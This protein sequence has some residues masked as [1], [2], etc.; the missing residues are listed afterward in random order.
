[1]KTGRE[2]FEK[3]Q[4]VINM[5]RG[6]RFGTEENLR[7][8][9]SKFG[10]TLPGMRVLWILQFEHQ[11]TITQI[12]KIGLWD[13]STTQRIITNLKK[14]N[15]VEVKKNNKDNR[16][17]IITLTDNSKQI[18]IN[19][20]KYVEEAIANPNVICSIE[21]S[22]YKFGEQDFNKFLDVGM[23]LCQEMIS[24]EYVDW[25]YHSAEKIKNINL[26]DQ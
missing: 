8:M 17:R 26:N 9:A 2:V 19:A 15:L 11:M 22:I 20:Y 21:K 16:K 14:A 12:S 23:Y 5:I 4:I 10:L 13:I 25:V 1:M 6:I 18:I 3:S 24:K 7:S